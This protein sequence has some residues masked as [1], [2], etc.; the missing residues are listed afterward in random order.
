MS[1]P[2]EEV[3][4]LKRTRD[5]LREILTMKAKDVKITELRAEAYSCLRHF[6]FDLVID[7]LWEERIKNT[8]T[9]SCEK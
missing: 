4:S 9:E 8:F 5:F 2:F 1:L 6:P 7:D 3:Y